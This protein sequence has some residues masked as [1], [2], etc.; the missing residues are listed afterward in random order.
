MGSS[1]APMAGGVG[2][3]ELWLCAGPTGTPQLQCTDEGNPY[4]EL[5][6][7]WKLGLVDDGLGLIIGTGYGSG[8]M[9]R[10]HTTPGL[11]DRRIV[12]PGRN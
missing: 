10:R 8:T 12:E 2:L 7:D 4:S 5:G 11:A 3:P 6:G 9:Y 1:D